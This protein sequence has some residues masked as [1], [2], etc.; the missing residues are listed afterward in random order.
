MGAGRS[1]SGFPRTETKSRHEQAISLF[2][3]EE[4]SEI[5]LVFQRICSTSGNS[6]TEKTAF[7]EQDLKRYIAGRVPDKITSKLFSILCKNGE[8]QSVSSEDFIIAVADLTKGMVEQQVHVLYTLVVEEDRTFTLSS[9]REVLHVFLGCYDA[10]LRSTQVNWKAADTAAITVFV[11]MMMQDLQDG[12]IES[13][14]DLC[15][16]LLNKPLIQN[17][18]TDIMHYCL[19][20]QH[21]AVKPCVFVFIGGSQCF[22]FTLS[23][24]MAIFESSS[25]NDHYM[26]LNMDQETLPN[27]LGMGGQFGYFGFWLD[28]DFGK[29]HS[30]SHP[31]CTTYD[32]PQLSATEQF[33]VDVL[34]VWA[35]G[36]IP[37]VNTEEDDDQSGSILDKNPE[38]KAL[39]DIIGKERK[40]EGLREDPEAD[41]PEVHQLP[42]L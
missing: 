5:K 37:K 31:K 33:T 19:L 2:S 30:K 28:Q 21:S 23:P 10:I 34:E 27:G 32:S 22:L 9:F 1:K 15:N 25:I 24:S 41:I 3:A 16:W 11:D 39:L 6:E 17:I 36:E 13:A 12:D 40:S 4:L 35:V 8:S 7:H 29:G 14:I 42:P 26:Y 18:L 20:I 38:A